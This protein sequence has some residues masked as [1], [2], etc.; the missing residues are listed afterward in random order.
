MKQNLQN[1]E[2]IDSEI[3]NLPFQ[4]SFFFAKKRIQLQKNKFLA[5]TELFAVKL[6]TQEN[7]GSAFSWA[8][9]V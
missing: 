8:L 1:L 3:D 4:I 5:N 9:R 2:L 6:T 7:T